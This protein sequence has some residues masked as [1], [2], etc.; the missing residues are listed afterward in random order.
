M[1]AYRKNFPARNLIALPENNMGLAFSRN[2]IK[3]YSRAQG[4]E[5]HWHADD[6]VM[7]FLNRVAGKK[8]QCTAME[9]LSRVES[10]VDRYSNIGIASLKQEVFAWSAK[11]RIDVNKSCTQFILVLNSLE[12]R[13]ADEIQCHDTDF[14]LQILRTGVY[15]TVVFNRFI[16]VTPTL[17]SNEGGLN[18]RYKSEE[19]VS[20]LSKLQERWPGTFKIVIKKGSPRVC[21]NGRIFSS[22]K[23]KLQRKA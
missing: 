10:Y 8:L 9:I 7:A 20:N 13:W 19:Y 6:D 16:I 17:G 12:Q 3:D 22:F 2:F 18:V 14:A 15:C 4:E 1:E 21:T 5:Y 11:N 23:Q